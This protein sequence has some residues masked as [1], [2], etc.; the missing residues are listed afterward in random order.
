MSAA[1]ASGAALA[2]VG[3][4]VELLLLPAAAVRAPLAAV[5]AGTSAARAAAGRIRGS[6]A[7]A[8]GILRQIRAEADAGARAI[9]RTARGAASAATGLAAVTAAARRI[10]SSLGR[11]DSALGGLLSLVGG[12]LLAVPQIAR[13]MDLF[14]KAATVAS[15]V[16]TAIDLLSRTTPIGLVTG[17]LLPLASQLI[18][19][20]VTSQ[21]GQRIIQQVFDQAARGLLQVATYLAP[22]L[23]VIGTVVATYFTAYLTVVVDVLTVVSALLTKGF[24]GMRAAVSS[25]V[26][27]LRGTV[28]GLWTSFR[29]AVRPVLDFL[30][31]DLPRAFQHVKDA[32][33]SALGGI[34]GFVRTGLQA[35][36]A[37]M[38]APLEGI[39][40]FANWVIEGLNSLGF[41]FLG[42][43]F[44]VHIDTIP[45]LAD[46][47]V[48]LPATARAARRVLPLTALDRR[49]RS[50]AAAGPAG[51]TGAAGG[52]YRIAAFHERPGDGARG[53]AEDLL[54]LAAT[55]ATATA[56]ATAPA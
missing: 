47:G 38:K 3:A 56:A 22:A 32:V 12:M 26:A 52:P 6:A 30:T 41:S 15:A 55:T 8:A 23:K 25:A 18:D 36:V 5:T 2:G 1:D 51:R 4:A 37:V 21:T 39:I 42:K 46:G 44:G 17:L 34:G 31:R 13:L 29:N 50:A 27:P 16:M 35:V 7:Q 20:A 40:G 45:M 10:R 24:P 54:F 53:I 48:V 33:A 14:G 49:L 9:T 28:S 11:L 43:H 19:L